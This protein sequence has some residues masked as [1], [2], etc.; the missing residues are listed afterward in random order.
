MREPLWAVDL[1][2]RLALMGTIWLASSE[3]R[4][5][6]I[7]TGT[8]FIIEPSGYILTNC[9]NVASAQWVKVV[10]YN[11]SKHDAEVVVCDE[12][13]DLALLKI[14][15]SGFPTVPIGSSQQAEVMDHVMVLGFPLIGAVGTEV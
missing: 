11:A 3:A 8:G 9:H 6:E 1:L 7:I 13:K 12:Y 5:E 10:L 15:G 4:C 2:R 14:E